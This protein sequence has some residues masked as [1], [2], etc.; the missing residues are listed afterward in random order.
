MRLPDQINARNTAWEQELRTIIEDLDRQ[1]YARGIAIT[2]ECDFRRMKAVSDGLEKL[3]LTP[4]FDPDRID[5]GPANGFWMK[6]VD[7]SGKVVLT[8]AARLYDCSNTTVALLHQ[9]LRAF[10]ADPTAAAEAGETCRC[11]AP[12]TH[13]LTGQML[14]RI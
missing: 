13:T 10:Y 2:L 8:Q 11:D 7:P 14:R 9:S 5:I 12:A 6:G 1:T 4:N 3:P